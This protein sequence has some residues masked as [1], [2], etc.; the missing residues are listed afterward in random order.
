MSYWQTTKSCS[1]VNETLGAF[2]FYSVKVYNSD[3]DD[4]S[5]G[6]N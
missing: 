4:K 2:V 5:K 3:Y 1:V 6:L